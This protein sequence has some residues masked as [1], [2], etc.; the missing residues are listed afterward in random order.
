MKYSIFVGR[1]KE[2]EDLQLLLRK[3]SASLVVVQGRRRIGKSRLIAEFGKE[4]RFYSFSGYPPVQETTA[5]AQRDEFAKQMG[6]AFG[7]SN[8]QADDWTTLFILFAKQVQ[9]GRV[10]ILFDEISWMG[11]KDPNFLG[12][13]KNAWD[14]YL[15]QNPELILI[16]CGSVS[17]WIER[18][19]LSSTGFLGRLSLVLHVEEL[20][21]KECS[22]LLSMMGSWASRYEK[23]K[24][25][26]VTGGIPRYLEEIQPSMTAEENI[27]RLCFQKSGILFREFKDI[28][29]DLFSKQSKFYQELVQLLK[30]ESLEFNDIWERLE[31]SKSG[32]LSESL[33]NLLK[34][35][36]ISRDY[37]WHFQNGKESKLS[38]YRLRDNYIRFYLKYILS[39]K[40]KIEQ[41]LFKTKSLAAFPGWET[42]MGFQFENLVLN[43]RQLIWQK[44]G[45]FSE[46]IV[47][48]GAFFQRKTSKTSGCQ[49]DYL[50]QTKF[51]NLFLCEVKF[52]KNALGPEV[53]KEML[54]KMKALIVP[55]G[56]SKLPVLIHVNGVQSGI[57]DSG[58]FTHIIDFS[59]F[60]E[61]DS[62]EKEK[63][64]LRYLLQESSFT[65]IG[66]Q[67]W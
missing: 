20:S 16:L 63:K 13:L 36:F 6:E 3:K 40:S 67:V 62:L 34:S 4:K 29:S 9:Q 7:L 11:S 32:Y 42:M 27:R 15:K 26:C 24:I 22:Y 51:N 12:K 64:A 44:L 59:E 45:L 19:I 56:F 5:E 65:G 39:N 38:R 21:L 25:F 55:K 58:F 52:S 28:F 47:M 60:L 30:N 18:N 49:I 53:E 14:L 2:L 50:I 10:V 1:K 61:E 54:A 37:T 57:V 41:G 8:I 23:F 17:P 66:D 33:D 48:E 43:N 35:G 31:M 46:M